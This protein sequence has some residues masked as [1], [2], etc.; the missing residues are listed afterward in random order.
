MTS[1]DR[2]TVEDASAPS[3]GA[4][5][6]RKAFHLAGGLTI[7]LAMAFATSACTPTLSAKEAIQKE[8]GSKLSPCANRIVSRESN[9]EPSAQNKS[10]GALGLFQLMPSHAAWIKKTFGYE[11]SEMKDPDKNAKVARAL[12][13][14]AYK[15][16]G[17]G[18]QPWRLS[19]RA[20]KGGGCPA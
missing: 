15:Y 6:S 12:S 14:E 13:N 18:W 1:P 2:S 3:T 8:W 5:R 4:R 16:W 17:D 11:W 10:S 20:V 7:V 9:F 19:N